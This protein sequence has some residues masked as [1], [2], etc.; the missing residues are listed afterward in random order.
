MK[1]PLE[2]YAAY[3]MQQ[4]HAKMALEVKDGMYL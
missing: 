3:Q 1:E 2:K 4:Q